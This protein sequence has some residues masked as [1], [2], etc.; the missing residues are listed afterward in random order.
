MLTAIVNNFK[1]FRDKI[2]SC[3]SYRS[4]ATMELVDALAGNTTADSVIGLSENS[5]F[6]RGYGSIHD[7]ISH[8]DQDS[9]QGER[10]EQCLLNHCPETRPFRLMVVDCTPAPRQHAKTLEDRGIVY[11]PNPVPGNKPISFG[12]QYSVMGFLPEQTS[13]QQDPPWML[14]I[15]VRRVPTDTNGINIGMEQITMAA[16]HFKEDLTVFLGDTQYSR[17]A[18]IERIQE[19]ENSLLGTVDISV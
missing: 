11:S 10:I 17:P 4:D 19:H 2:F 5:A 8:F 15:S 13:R 18:L 16:S 3:F 9:K 12:H 14:P 7:V 6:R 1:S